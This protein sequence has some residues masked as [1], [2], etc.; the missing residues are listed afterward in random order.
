YGEGG[1]DFIIVGSATASAIVYGDAPG[2][3]LG[4]NDTIFGNA[5]DDTLV[6]GSGSGQNPGSVIYGM[7]SS[8]SNDLIVGSAGDD[9]L[10]GGDGSSTVYGGGESDSIYGG[11]WDG[12]QVV[13]IA[14]PGTTLPSGMVSSSTLV[15]GGG[16]NL[17]WGGNATLPTDANGFYVN[18]PSR[19]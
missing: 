11:A 1:N 8:A 9:K 14:G 4:G 15:A 18:D 12:G 6:A 17:M 5:G 7:G 13:L 19:I 2:Q 10:V 3:A 16:N